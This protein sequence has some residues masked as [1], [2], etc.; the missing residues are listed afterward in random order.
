MPH[1]TVIIATYNR[2]R[3]LRCALESLVGQT[4]RD[5][6]AWIV[7]DACT[8]DS[9][10]VVAR[11]D[12]ARLHWTNLAARVGH[13]SGPNNEGLRRAAAPWI[14]YLGHDDLWFPWHLQSLVETAERA[15]ADF[16]Y[17]GV[18]FVGPEGPRE[19]YGDRKRTAQV[20]V[21]PPSGWLHRREVAERCGPWREPREEVTGMDVGFQARAS[22]AGFRFAGSRNMS[23]LKFPSPWWQTYTRDTGFPQETCLARLRADA[24]GLQ[25]EVLSELVL[26]YARRCDEASVTV[27]L[28]SAWRGA[29]RYLGERYG[30]DRWP[31][32]SY[33]RWRHLHRREQ[34]LARRGLPRPS[35]ELD[36][37]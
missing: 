10:D 37:Q 12:D 29:Q 21:A 17:G 8:D 7:G 35:R 19:A 27:G 33:L 31:L 5:F 15:R 14:A 28:K 3:L 16:A 18:V 23:V 2:S 4:Y 25:G 11:M 30:V 6:E 1:V 22:L 13:Q 34:A 36:G 20:S 9:A 24:R 32:R 26:T